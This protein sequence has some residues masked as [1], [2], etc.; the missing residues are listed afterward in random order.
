[1]P[2]APAVHYFLGIFNPQTIS[3][4]N[5]AITRRL[6]EVG[7]IEEFHHSLGLDMMPGEKRSQPKEVFG[8]YDFKRKM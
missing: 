2:G 1:M 4:D 3:G 8:P 7:V 6:V 5:A